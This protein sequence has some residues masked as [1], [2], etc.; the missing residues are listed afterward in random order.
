MVTGT[1]LHLI[2]DFLYEMWSKWLGYF[3]LRSPFSVSTIYAVLSRDFGAVMKFMLELVAPLRRMIYV[4]D[5]EVF[6]DM[7][8]VLQ[9]V[10]QNC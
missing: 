2:Y 7:L 6:P 8:S 5:D 10:E 4:F 1:L 3:S 9:S